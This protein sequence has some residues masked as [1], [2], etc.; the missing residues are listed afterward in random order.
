[1]TRDDILRVAD[2]LFGGATLV[3]TVLG[4]KNGFN[5]TEEQLAL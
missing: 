1:V 5:L 3:G 4:P 2:M